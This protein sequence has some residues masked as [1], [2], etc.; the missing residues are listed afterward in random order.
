MQWRKESAIFVAS[1]DYSRR[2]ERRSQNHAV[3]EQGRFVLARGAGDEKTSRRRPKFRHRKGLFVT[4]Y[5]EYD[6]SV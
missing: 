1:A 6:V 2:P 3:A 4:S 5:N